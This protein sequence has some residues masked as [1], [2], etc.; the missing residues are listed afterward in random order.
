MIII[1]VPA[2]QPFIFKVIFAATI[3]LV[4]ASLCAGQSLP[5][6]AAD[7]QLSFSDNPENSLADSR[8]E[9]LRLL[10]ESAAL[11]AEPSIDPPASTISR[12]A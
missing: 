9:I 11:S 5:E 1:S 4:A 6:P 8:V 3:Y 10:A 2:S 7:Q 12:P